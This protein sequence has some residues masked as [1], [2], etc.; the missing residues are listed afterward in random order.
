MDEA[1]FL[2]RDG[3]IAI[4][5]GY[6]KRPEDFKLYPDSAMAIKQMNE[7]GYRVIVIT[8]Q[9]GLGRGYFTEEDLMLVHK[10]LKWQLRLIGAYVDAIYYCPH[11]P[12]E[13]YGYKWSCRC[14]KPETELLE[15]AAEKYSID[16][17]KSWM[18]GDQPMDISA[19]AMVG[20]K[21]ICVKRHPS[22]YQSEYFKDKP[23]VVVSTLQEAV[24]WIRK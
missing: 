19:G 24:E 11:A 16:F 23:N 15:K 8:N 13:R 22:H 3:T 7:I 5:V 6:C 21:T 9:S 2:D 20:C 12:D 4:D 14:R 10:E 17:S 1:I 18:I